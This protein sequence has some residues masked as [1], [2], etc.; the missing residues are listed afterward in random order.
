M[1]YTEALEKLKKMLG[2]VTDD[3]AVLLAYLDMAKD[4]ILTWKYPEIVDMD[5]SKMDLP[6]AYEGKQIRIAV[7][8][9]NKRGAEGE[10]QHIENG[11]HRN[12]KYADV[13]TELLRDIPPMCG[14]PR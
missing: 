7:W 14:I 1:A 9:L 2:E 11:I 8:M 3:D 4:A 13:P 12:Y 6:K 10:V 5:V